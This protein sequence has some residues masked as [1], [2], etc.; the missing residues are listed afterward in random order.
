MINIGLGVKTLRNGLKYTKLTRKGSKQLG[1]IAVTLPVFPWPIKK[2]YL[3]TDDEVFA[4]LELKYGLGKMEFPMSES[5]GLTGIINL[6][7]F[8]QA[9]LIGLNLDMIK[10]KL[11]K[12]PVFGLAD[13]VDTIA[14]ESIHAV[15][16]I[17][18]LAGEDQRKPGNHS[19]SMAYLGGTLAGLY[20]NMF[21]ILLSA[22][23]SETK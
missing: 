22:N 20:F 9:I 10:E 23:L 1:G 12:D 6:G 4:E 18:D 21:L 13:V 16:D 17:I 15:F 8:D 5:L 3:V 19:E 14:H 11:V 2:F 7:E